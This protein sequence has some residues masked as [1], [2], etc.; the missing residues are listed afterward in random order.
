M[1]G[2]VNA[3]P[4]G[5]SS[6]RLL[7]TLLPSF[8]FL[9]RRSRRFHFGGQALVLS[10][11]RG[12]PPAILK[13]ALWHTSV[14]GKKPIF[15]RFEVPWSH[16]PLD[17]EDTTPKYLNILLISPLN[18]PSTVTFQQQFP[19]SGRWKMKKKKGEHN[20][21]TAAPTSSCHLEKG[22]VLV[23]FAYSPKLQK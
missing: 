2:P 18:K 14:W 17:S 9:T 6:R 4:P 20:S 19:S 5:R 22:R 23:A 11:I 12:T 10:T 21:K 1:S 15:P 8:F 3:F 7:L 16:A 13:R